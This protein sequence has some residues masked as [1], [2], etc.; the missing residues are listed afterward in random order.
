MNSFF[1]LTSL[2]DYKSLIPS[3]SPPQEEVRVPPLVNNSCY[4]ATLGNNRSNDKGVG[5]LALL[6]AL[7]YFNNRLGGAMFPT[8]GQDSGCRSW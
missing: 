3:P 1:T 5:Y 6:G 7:K 4:R 8:R 2:R